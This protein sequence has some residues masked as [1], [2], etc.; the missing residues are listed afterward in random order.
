MS[1]GPDV[2]GDG[3]KTRKSRV[4]SSP[5][6]QQV[7]QRHKSTVFTALLTLIASS[8]QGSLVIEEMCKTHKLRRV[9]D[10]SW[11]PDTLVSCAASKLMETR[12]EKEKVASCS[13]KP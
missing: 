7:Q 8:H 9:I 3:G 1:D 10:A 2:H 13:F 5:R 6:Q 12:I 11:L 4:G